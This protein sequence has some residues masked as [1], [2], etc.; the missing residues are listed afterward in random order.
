MTGKTP[1]LFVD[2]DVLLLCAHVGACGE[3]TFLF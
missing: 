3:G 1:V 2:D